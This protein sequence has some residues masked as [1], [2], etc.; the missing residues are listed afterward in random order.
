MTQQK[1]TQRGG[2]LVACRRRTAHVVIEVWDTG[3][4]IAEQHQRAIFDEF[5][6]LDRGRRSQVL[7]RVELR[8]VAVVAEA[9]HRSQDQDRTVV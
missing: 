6:R 2:V 9:C 8:P 4:G 1:Y 7:R 3:P 5:R